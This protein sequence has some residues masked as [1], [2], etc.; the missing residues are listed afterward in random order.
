MK[1]T[2]P[3]RTTWQIANSLLTWA[4]HRPYGKA[5]KFI[6]LST[7]RCRSLIPLRQVV[8]SQLYKYHHQSGKRQNSLKTASE[9]EAK[10]LPQGPVTSFHSPCLMAATVWGSNGSWLTMACLLWTFRL[11]CFVFFCFFGRLVLE[12]SMLCSISWRG[13]TL[14]SLD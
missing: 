12:V 9:G 14:P 10:Y 5:G 2:L 4:K 11:N 13:E 7:P 3:W 1:F 8:L 6:D